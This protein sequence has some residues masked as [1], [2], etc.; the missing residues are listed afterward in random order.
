MNAI[1]VLGAVLVVV[2]GVLL[3]YGNA[4]RRSVGNQLNELIAGEPTRD[5]TVFFAAGG[6]A[7]LIGALAIVFGG[8]KRR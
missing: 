3:Y 7:L 5:V 1:R 4:A 6:A 8:G 2:G